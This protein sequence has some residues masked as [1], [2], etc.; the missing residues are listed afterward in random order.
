M[1]TMTYTYLPGS[2][3]SNNECCVLQLELYLTM[4]ATFVCFS[5][6]QLLGR[7]WSEKGSSFVIFSEKW[8]KDIIIGNQIQVYPT[9]R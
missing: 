3:M 1:V 7:P 6:E 9:F 8:K 5:L 2:F 4:T